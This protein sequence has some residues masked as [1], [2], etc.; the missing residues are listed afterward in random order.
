MSAKDEIKDV[1]RDGVAQGQAK[2]GVIVPPITKEQRK[3]VATQAVARW[4]VRL[5]NK[6]FGWL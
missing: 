4:Y 5:W 2:T 3:E 6:L 1:L